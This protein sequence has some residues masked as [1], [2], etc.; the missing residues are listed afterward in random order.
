[1]LVEVGLALQHQKKKEEAQEGEHNSQLCRVLSSW[2][3]IDLVSIQAQAITTG[4]MGIVNMWEE[5]Q[6]TRSIH[7]QDI[8]MILGIAPDLHT[9]VVDLSIKRG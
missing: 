3:I 5:A 2:T 7:P 4:A 6:L 1:M 9:E 8:P